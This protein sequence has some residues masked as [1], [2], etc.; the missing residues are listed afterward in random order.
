MHV[1]DVPL[2]GATLES[3]LGFLTFVF[4]STAVSHLLALILVQLFYHA[5]VFSF[6]LFIFLILLTCLLS[7]NLLQLFAS[8]SSFLP[9]SLM[10]RIKPRYSI[11]VQYLYFFNPINFKICVGIQFDWYGGSKVATCTPCLYFYLHS[12]S[13]SIICTLSRKFTFFCSSFFACNQ[14]WSST[15]C[16]SATCIQHLLHTFS[17][18]L[19]FTFMFLISFLYGYTAMGASHTLALS[20]LVSPSS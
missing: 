20:F 15:Q 10:H 11:H 8:F 3:I 18:S 2:S 1:R 5:G 9:S 4:L 7:F 19:T 14:N 12:L 13:S 16:I 6:Y 17:R